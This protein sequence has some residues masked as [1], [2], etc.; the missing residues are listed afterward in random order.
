MLFSSFILP[1]FFSSACAAAPRRYDAAVTRSL[2]RPSINFNIAAES[3]APGLPL[4][5]C[6]H[7]SDRTSCAFMLCRRSFPE[8][9]K[10]P[11]LRQIDIRRVPDMGKI[12]VACLVVNSHCPKSRPFRGL[13]R[14]KRI[15][16]PPMSRKVRCRSAAPRRNRY[17]A[18]SC[19]FHSQNR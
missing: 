6:P 5:K 14:V 12:P 3:G 10:I 15:F 8:Y 7:L 9:I 13:K 17:P 16:K 18:G 11:E 19:C 2:Q 4:E 1:F